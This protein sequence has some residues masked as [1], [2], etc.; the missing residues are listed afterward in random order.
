MSAPIE[1]YALISDL[2]TAAMVGRDG[3]VDWL[4]LPRFDSPAC[5]AALLGTLD[6]GFWRVAP[7]APV[8][9]AQRAYR[10][11]TLVL[12]TRWE[13]PTGTVRVIDFMPPRAQLPCVVRVI[14]G[15]SGAVP[16][17][18]E[19]RLRFHQ[20]RVVPWIRAVDRCAVA[21]AGPDAVWLDADGPVSALD[22]EDSTL[23]DFTVPAGRRLALTL[24]WSPSHVPQTPAPLSV[25][26]ETLLKET[27]DF[28]R[29]WS[30]R[31][32]YEGPWQDAV[33]RS[34]ITLKA[35]TYAPT[36]GVV[37]A[38][39]TSLPGCIGGE[40]NWDHRYCWLRDSTLT[41]SCL[42]RSGYRDEAAAWVDWLVR[43]IAGDPTDLQTVYGV[44][45]Q[46]LLPET[47]APWLLGYEGSRPVRFGNSAAGQFQ[48]D[49][50]GEILD[51]LCLSLR[52][53]IP[54]PAH[55]WSLV[56]AM[57][58]YLQRHWREPDHGLWQVRGRGRQFVHSK[59]MAWV[60]AD[61]AVRMGELLGRNGSS[62]QW[63]AMR[64]EVHR[65][66]CREGWDA[67]QQSFVQS[68]GSTAL[69]ASALLMPRL[70]FL[71][72]RDERVR[73]TVRAM[74][75]LDH[76]G[77]VRR[78][79]ASGDG[80]HAVDGVRGS[81]GAFVACS[82]WYADALAGTGRAEQAREVF[83]RVLATRNDVGLLAE[84]WAPDTGRQLGNAPQASSHI[85]L[86]ETAFA[87][88]P[89]SPGPASRHHGRAG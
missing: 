4:C 71:P 79:A 56:E 6:N 63:R 76:G 22:R 77:F 62:G 15:L 83:E 75:G 23:Y 48:L 80:V 41:L 40:R 53:G 32:R 12:D 87:L 70:G 84:Q 58:G 78:Y 64:D 38:P 34:L 89:S 51:A 55:V 28:W 17:R 43:A 16:M 33:V 24:A 18:S 39:T 45:G 46:R 13:T 65:Q 5:L 72:A 42:L 52:A 74:R 37:A 19:L 69:D 8:A 68:Y 36:G 11:D 9:C 29:R 49:V 27:G 35:L 2:E 66:V 14:E 26:A 88:S 59:V 20:G 10:P 44:G 60:A 7:V 21:V 81:E 67:H 25:P 50:Y 73:G 47:E 1:D 54:M 3:S 85:A 61:R 31:C 30:A 57:M 82:L 86:V